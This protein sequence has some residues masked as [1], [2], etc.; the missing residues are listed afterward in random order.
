M[1]RYVQDDGDEDTTAATHAKYVMID[2]IKENFILHVVI[3]WCYYSTWLVEISTSISTY[4]IL[5]TII[6]KFLS[7]SAIIT[8]GNY[9][10]DISFIGHLLLIK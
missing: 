5:M 10:T 7:F 9:K 1:E 8:D 2:N 4:K 3:Y 6:K